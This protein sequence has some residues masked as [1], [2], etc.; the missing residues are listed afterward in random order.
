MCLKRHFCEIDIEKM[1]FML[2]IMTNYDAIYNKS[3]C[4]F[5]QMKNHFLPNTELI[6]ASKQTTTFFSKTQVRKI[7]ISLLRNSEKKQKHFV[8]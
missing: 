6:N 2:L 5:S 8:R 4:A 7:R 1:C 3:T